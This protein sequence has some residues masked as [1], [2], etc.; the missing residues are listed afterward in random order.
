M[1]VINTQDNGSMEKKMEG[2]L[3]FTQ[4]K[5]ATMAVG[6][7]DLI[8]DMED[9]LTLMEMSTKDNSI[10]KWSKVKVPTNG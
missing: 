9:W 10:N 4:I 1:K 7:M 3:K 6:K 5:H 2:E 8:M